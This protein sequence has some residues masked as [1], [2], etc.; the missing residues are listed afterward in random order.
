MQIKEAQKNIDK[1]SDS[2]TTKQENQAE[3]LRKESEKYKLFLDKNKRIQDRA[4][5]DA[6]NEITQSI[7][8]AMENGSAK[9]LAQRELN[10]K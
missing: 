4:E 1:Y 2:K 10:H 3:K 8:D 6:Q 9:T 5:V 7:I